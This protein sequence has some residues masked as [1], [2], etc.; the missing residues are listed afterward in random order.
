VTVLHNG[1]LV[2]LNE[3]IRGDTGHRIAAVYKQRIA[4]GPLVLGGHGC[5]V[6]FRNIWIRPL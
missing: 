1:V 3:E 2:H 5:P 4:K 6:R